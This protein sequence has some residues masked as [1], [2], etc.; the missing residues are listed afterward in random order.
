MGIY[1]CAV[2]LASHVTECT[3][4]VVTPALLPYGATRKVASWIP[5]SNRSLE[6]AYSPRFLVHGAAWILELD[7]MFI[8]DH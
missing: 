7:R 2:V 6:L 3:V 5:A 1:A 4:H 8:C